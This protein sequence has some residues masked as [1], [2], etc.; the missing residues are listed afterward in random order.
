MT[1]HPHPIT[2]PPELV[3]EWWDAALP[4]A[5]GPCIKTQLCTQAARWGADQ[6]LQACCSEMDGWGDIHYS[7]GWKFSKNLRTARRASLKEQALEALPE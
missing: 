5:S 2:P 4:N 1:K 6:E 3:R 7:A